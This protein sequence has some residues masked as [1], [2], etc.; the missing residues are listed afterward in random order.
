MSEPILSPSIDPKDV[1]QGVKVI[2][3]Q[4]TKLV[5][6][7]GKM[8]KAFDDFGDGIAKKSRP[9]LEALKQATVGTV[10]EM[11]KQLE[12]LVD[13]NDKMAK[14]LV[15]SQGQVVETHRSTAKRVQEVIR[16]HHSTVD[17]LMNNIEDRAKKNAA[18]MLGADTVATRAKQVQA[19]M[20]GHYDA[21]GL[22][23]DQSVKEVEASARAHAAKMVAVDKLRFQNFG[24]QQA[25]AKTAYDMDMAAMRAHYK[26]QEASALAHATKMEEVEKL[27]FRNFG[28]RQA[29]A[30]TA[31]ATDMAAMRAHYKAQEASALAHATKMAEIDRRQVLLASNNPVGRYSSITGPTTGT[32]YDVGPVQRF[33]SAQ[34]QLNATLRDG[35]S[36]ARG[37]ASGFGAMWLTWGNIGPLLAG[38]AISNALVQ[39]VKSGADVQQS[40]TQ[41][42]VL[43]GETAESVG[44]LNDQ[45]LELARSGP[46]GP[47]EI[48]EAFRVMALAGLSAQSASEAV[49]DVLNFSL[50]GDIGIKEAADVLTSVGTAFKI[51]SD[52][53]GYISDVISKAAAESK[54]SVEDFSGAMKTASVINIQYGVSLEETAVGISL[55]ANAGIRG[56]AA[57]T[58]LRNMYADLSGR[59]K[60]V[61]KAMTELGVQALDPLTGKMRVTQGVFEDLIKALSE[62]SPT[63]ASGYI[64]RI[65]SERGSKE[66]IAVMDALRTKAQALGVDAGSVYEELAKKVAEASGFAAIA[67]AEMSLTPL[68]QMKSVSAALQATLVET[69]E[70]LQPFVLQISRDLKDIFASD[71]FKAGLQDLAVGVGNIIKFVVEWSREIATVLLA[72]KG[73]TA[74]L[75]IMSA[76]SAGVAAIGTAAATTGVAFAGMS[77]A[78]RA[79]TLANPILL[80]ITA[81]VTAAAAAWALLKVNTDSATEKPV[82]E[83]NMPELTKALEAELLH[84][85]N[86]NQARRERISLMELEARQKGILAGAGAKTE[87]DVLRE[88]REQAAQALRDA[89]NRPQARGIMGSAGANSWDAVADDF[90]RADDAYRAASEKARKELERYNELL[91]QIKGAHKESADAARARPIN[92]LGDPNAKSTPEKDEKAIA[93]A[94]KAMEFYNDLMDKSSGYSKTYAEDQ[95]KLA[96]ALRTGAI[97]SYEDYVLA[98]QELMAQQPGAI[99]QTKAEAEARKE[100]TKALNEFDS[101]N[102]KALSASYGEVEKAQ[103]AYD[104]HG[105]LASVLQEEVLARLE[106]WRVITA[107]GGEDTSVLDIEIANKKKLIEILRN[108][109]FRD[110]NEKAAKA[111]ADAWE[112]INEQIGQSLTDQLMEGGRSAADYLK[113]LFRTLVLRPVIM[114]GVTSIT[115]GIADAAGLGAPGSS[116]SNL[117]GTASSLSNLY[118]LVSG[119][120]NAGL[121]GGLQV[122]KLVGEGALFAGN[123]TVAGFAGGMMSTSTMAAATAAAQA[124]GAQ[125]AGLIAG[126]FG[127]AM[128]GYAL[129]KAISGGY[130]VNSSLNKIGA[131]AS[132]IPGVRPIA[133]AITGLINRAFGRKATELLS[134]GTRGTFSGESF[135]GVNYANYQKKGGWFRSDKNWTDITAMNADAKETWSETFAGVKGSVAGM[136]E[137]LGLSTNKILSYSKY[138]DVA[139]GTTEEQVTALF[140]NMADEMARTVLGTTQTITTTTKTTLGSL[141]SSLSSGASGVSGFMGAFLRAVGDKT[142]TTTTFTPNAFIRDG[143][144]AIAA[145]ERLSSSLQAANFWMGALSLTTFD[146]SLVGADAASKLADAF[147]GL[148]NMA[149]ASKTYYDLFWSDAEKLADTAANVTKGLALVGIAMPT[150][151]EAF[152]DVV[153]SLDL[154]TEAGRNAYAVML[155]LAPEFATVADAMGDVG[156]TLEALMKRLMDSLGVAKDQITSGSPT[157]ATKLTLNPQTAALLAAQQKQV[158]TSTA[159]AQARSGDASAQTAYATAKASYG[160]AVTL[161]QQSLDST[162]SYYKGLSAHFRTYASLFKL[163]VSATGNNNDAY[164][165]NDQTNQLSGW[166][167]TTNRGHRKSSHFYNATNEFTAYMTN[168]GTLQALQVGNSAL[169]TA[170]TNLTNAQAAYTNAMAV[171]G[172]AATASAQTLAAATTASVAAKDAFN[173]ALTSYVTGLTEAV[174]AF[175]ALWQDTAVA[176]A[177]VNMDDLLAGMSEMAAFAFN[178]ERV[179]GMSVMFD[180]SLSSAEELAELSLKTRQ[181]ELALLRNIAQLSDSINDSFSDTIRSFTLDT[182]DTDQ[183]YAFF[184]NEIAAYTE[185]LKSASDP[186]LISEYTSKIQDA[187]TSAWALLDASQKKDTLAE[188]TGVLNDANDLS[189]D[190]LEESANQVVE[191]WQGAADALTASISKAID[192]AMARAAAAIALAA[193]TPGSVTV[194]LDTS[195][196]GANLSASFNELITV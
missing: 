142:T 56:T 18:L 77:L 117:M 84:I 91:A 107:M 140:N 135:E 119:G 139:A 15:R 181:D 192:D 95:N 186:E 85:N 104:A 36:A 141:F 129:S 108:G 164:V 185:M 190:R 194:S 122:A 13:A 155:A 82:S 165:Y 33:T 75:G 143:E 14:E 121:Q 183:K 57:G 145:L 88:T 161:A 110:A 176:M 52:G 83:T 166:T 7:V 51:S 73:F 63:E 195:A 2:E 180:G 17:A 16:S 79:A 147:G 184:D 132:M 46:F 3:E 24:L 74:V 10:S 179:R 43:A 53:Y 193:A 39:M 26:A 61:Q 98:V 44:R 189:Q 100:L 114:A 62:K 71:G 113:N 137:S 6:Q 105:K 188:F 112:K 149:N 191:I 32:T 60:D 131:I 81:V 12:Y 20:K 151:K 92:V 27:R 177:Q 102:K 64:S 40:L 154:T 101:A 45:M 67:A 172:A 19:V 111:A 133:G 70:S 28:L 42:R 158:T 128:S 47:K 116:G 76:V 99:A 134:S 162:V 196:S 65:F 152:R 37:L 78:M 58:A 41:V 170:A 153:R 66:A 144:T 34:A 167:N 126:T 136:A 89:G 86:V 11:V 54:S 159:L 96:L 22:Y 90:K 178:S 97:A 123:A 29:E 157:N 21:L 182:L 124:G 109:E 23:H 163:N 174:E 125:A 169:T 94:A 127:N 49:Q 68:N 59:T 171:T 72:Y 25:E 31:Y 138:I 130:Q 30:R 168:S 160:A 5:G 48:A 150:T 146:V 35:H 173:A 55:L 4:A 9:G 93:E 187:T 106:N 69:F 38:A 115:G 148:E 87:L 80:G 175:T 120:L 103:A 50:A 8:S 1:V 156:A 118:N